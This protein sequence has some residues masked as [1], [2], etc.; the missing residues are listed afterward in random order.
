[1]QR[2]E[3]LSQDLQEF[4]ARYGLVADLKQVAGVLSWDQ[5]TYMPARSAAAR[6]QQ[7]ATLMSL[8]HTKLTD[9]DYGQLLE[10]L[11]D[12][13]DGLTAVQAAEVR[14]AK[15]EYDLHT[16]LPASLVEELG[17]S[18]A[19]GQQIWV[20]ARQNNDFSK[21]LPALQR[22]ISLMR[23]QADH[24]G[25]EDHP[26]DALHDQYE[27]GSTAAQV[28]AVFGP[29]RDATTR[30]LDKIRNSSV[31]S[32]DSLLHG[33]WPAAAQEKFGSDIAARFGFD[34]SRGRLD[35]TVHPFA[36]GIGN[37]DV[38]ITTRY[39]EKFVSSAL[40]SILH[41]A[42]HGIYEQGI[43]DGL[44]RTAVGDSVSLAV[45]ESQ[46]RMWENLIGRSDVFWQ[47]AWPQFSEHFPEALKGVDRAEF[48]RA[49]NHVEPSL[50]R[51]EADEVTYNLHIM[52][53]FELE[54]ALLEG[55]L[56]P[57]DLPQ[58]WNGLYR[59]YLGITPEND[60]VGCLQDV[61]W[62]AGLVGYFPTYSLG[63]LMSVQLL[64]A[65]RAVNPELDSQILH[66]DFSQ[67][68]GWLRSNVHGHG[69][70]LSPDELVRA[71]TGRSLEAAPYVSYLNRKYGELYGFTPEGDN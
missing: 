71:A 17:R 32:S 36:V 40:F 5:Q 63:N 38:R 9:R 25:Y 69:S 45:H 51:V 70:I 39:D 67:L 15:R 57:S 27:P 10:R 31:R 66:G 53:R 20:E 19:E 7:T 59:D 46:S 42:G 30:L 14:E 33:H 24:L 34:F 65:H 2:S 68:L 1:M 58:A 61:H 62:S 28:K 18:Q 49:I 12:N 8:L 47:Y 41:E 16:K 60:S 26:Y 3:K 35:P 37:S 11:Q 6:G 23:Q 4:R 29:L 13:A 55:S 64:D 52:I 50:I 44:Q 56:D 54:L 21:Y 43:P 22:T 48:H